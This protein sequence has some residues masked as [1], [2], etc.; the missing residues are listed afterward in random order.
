MVFSCCNNRREEIKPMIQNI[1]ESVYAAGTIKTKNQYEVVPTVTGI[2]NKLY[3]KENDLVEAGT[4]LMQVSDETSKLNRQNAALAANYATLSVNR[5]KL[6]DL[7]NNITLARSKYRNDSLLL[8]RQQNLWTQNIGTRWE[9][10]QRELSFQSSAT[11]LESAI[12][13][14]S[15]LQKELSYNEKQ[16]RNNLAI[17][18]SREGDFVIKS[19]I[20]GKIYS[21]PRERGE[22]VNPQTVVALIGD[23]ADFLLGLQIDEYD[24]VKIK[25]NQKVL[26]SMD[27]YKGETFEA[28]VSKIY[29]LMNARTKSFYVEAEFTRQPPVLYPNLTVEAN[30]V[31]SVKEN[32]LTIPRN[33][34]ISDSL[35]L[36]TKKHHTKAIVTGLKDYQRVEV[37][38]GLTADD[39]IYK[40]LQ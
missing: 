18:K 29:P 26:V 35:V 1:T 32:V 23:A 20:G 16:T 37:I 22:I 8:I 7:E 5:E 27:S 31:I 17:T 39:I 13:K 14:Y 10:E 24:I 9:L 34:L 15:N 6:T 40:P 38:H 25:L 21:L 11:A 19:E 36:V 4:P 30:I 2:I 12:L 33:Y 28:R 3:V